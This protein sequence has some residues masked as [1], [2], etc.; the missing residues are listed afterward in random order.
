MVELQ[1]LQNKAKEYNGKC[2]STVYINSKYKYFWECEKKHQWEATWINVGYKNATWCKKCSFEESKTYFD[3]EMG[4]QI[5]KEKGGDCLKHTKGIVGGNSGIYL[6]KCYKGH[7][8]ETS[9]SNIIVGKSWCKQC[10]KLTIEDCIEE[11]NKRGG[12]CLDSLYINRR[13]KMNWECKNSHKFSLTMG[14]VRNSN[15]WCREC[16][17]DSQKLDISEPQKTARERGGKCLSTT[18]INCITPMRWQ[19]EFGHEWEVSYEGIRRS[20]NWCPHCKFKSEQ[21]T[22]EVFEKLFNEKF[23]KVH[24]PFME[25]LELDG[26]CEKY[27]IAFEYQGIQHYEFTSFFHNSVDDFEKQKERD[28]RK[29]KLCFENNINLIEISCKYNYK[30]L[31]ELIW[32]IRKSIEEQTEWIFIDV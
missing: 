28:E 10:R 2:L 27:N 5:A 16:F 9:A 13:T 4:K 6:W 18:Y 3:L 14:N 23:P 15:R 8:W 12:K 22:R 17:V 21:A 24:L 32:Y 30:N 20:N 31:E 26:Y 11:A 1:D 19:C 25:R 29:K 7:T